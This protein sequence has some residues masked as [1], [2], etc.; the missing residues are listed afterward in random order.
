LPPV[1]GCCALAPP[2]LLWPATALGVGMRTMSK[3][4]L[5]AVL[6]RLDLL[7]SRSA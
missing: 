7:A 1:W 5:A 6:S 4:Q 2:W 3:A